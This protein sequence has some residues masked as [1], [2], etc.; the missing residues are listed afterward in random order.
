MNSKTSM[1]QFRP[2]L[3]FLHWVIALVIFAPLAFGTL[4]LAQMPNAAPMKIE[5]LRVDMTVGALVGL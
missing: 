2:V 1:T 4:H 3:V 5:S